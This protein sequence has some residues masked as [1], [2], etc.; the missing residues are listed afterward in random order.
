MAEHENV[1]PV[2][3]VCSIDGT[4]SAPAPASDAER[5]ERESAAYQEAVRG[6]HA[7]DVPAIEAMIAERRDFYLYVGR[8]T[9]RWCRRL[10][11]VMAPV[12]AKRAI[13]VYYLD[14]TDSKTDEA[15]SAFRDRYGVTWVPTVLHFDAAG[16]VH[17]LE[18]D[19][20]VDDDALRE[21]LERELACGFSGTR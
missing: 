9:C 4:C 5:V 10:I 12:F 2:G 14:S 11:P 3:A 16:T 13:D 20:D 6:F 8:V 18:V 21:A 7:V 17:G 19:L 15:L 1:Q